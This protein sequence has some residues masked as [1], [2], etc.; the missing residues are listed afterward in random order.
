MAA[1]VPYG[2]IALLGLAGAS[3]A[4]AG[5][6]L[7]FEAGQAYVGHILDPWRHARGEA[8]LNLLLGGVLLV[9]AVALSAAFGV[10]LAS[11]LA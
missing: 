10:R 4:L 5:A 7:L 8:A 6:C 1:L 9:L 11:V 2:D 3:A